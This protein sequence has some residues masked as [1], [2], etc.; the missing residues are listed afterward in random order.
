[1]IPEPHA[2]ALEQAAADNGRTIAS[3][4]RLALEAW[5]K[6]HGRIRP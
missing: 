1:M 5:L 2:K 6:E 4:I 3:E